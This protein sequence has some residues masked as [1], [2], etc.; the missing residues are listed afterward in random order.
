[1]LGQDCSTRH[2]RPE[3]DKWDDHSL[4]R[5]NNSECEAVLPCRPGAEQLEGRF[6]RWELGVLMKNAL[7]HKPTIHLVVF[8]RV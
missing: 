3:W 5:F 4:M 7:G 2:K 8:A 6:E 1:M